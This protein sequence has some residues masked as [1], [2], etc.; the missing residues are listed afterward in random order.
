MA[1][2]N[3]K[4]YASVGRLERSKLVHIEKMER[5]AGLFLW[6]DLIDWYEFFTPEELREMSRP[7]FMEELRLS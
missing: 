3:G 7:E 1:W 4:T 6:S 2:S 5:T